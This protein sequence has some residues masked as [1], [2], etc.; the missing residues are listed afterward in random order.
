MSD[1]YAFA[2]PLAR[3]E[4]DS[5]IANAMTDVLI[6]LSTTAWVWLVSLA[7]GC[8]LRG[9]VEIGSGIA[10]GEHEVYGQALAAAHHLESKVAK[11]PRIVAGRRLLRFLW[12][13]YE[14]REH[15][16]P[17]AQEAGRRA[18]NCLALLN[19]YYYNEDHDAKNDDG[20]F[21]IDGFAL[22]K[23]IDLAR[24]MF[25]GAFDY[26]RRELDVHMRAGDDRLV[27]RYESLLA[28]FERGRS[29]F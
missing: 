28:H 8:P 29:T 2:V 25:D 14:R 15:R 18:E 20:R 4:T 1:A 6:S 23:S 13:A 16:Y 11:A 3:P 12:G 27:S 26:V 5:D 19:D 17:H 21:V 22:A 24:E 7:H 9:G 10:I